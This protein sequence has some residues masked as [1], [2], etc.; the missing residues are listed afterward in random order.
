MLFSCTLSIRDHVWNFVISVKLLQIH[1]F[2]VWQNWNNARFFFQ[3][4]T[5]CVRRYAICSSLNQISWRVLEGFLYL[6]KVRSLFV[7]SFNIVGWCHCNGHSFIFN[8]I[9]GISKF[10]EVLQTVNTKPNKNMSLSLYFP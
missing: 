8:C 6:K 5:V 9:N 7:C 1:L 3:Y 4:E 10:L 2:I